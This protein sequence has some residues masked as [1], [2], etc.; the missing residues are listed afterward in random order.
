[1][2]PAADDATVGWV[3]DTWQR[4]QPHSDG[5]YLNFLDGDDSTGFGPPSHP[6]TGS[7][8]WA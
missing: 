4:L 5:A 6:R 7:G 1:M 2:D 8:Y 3:R